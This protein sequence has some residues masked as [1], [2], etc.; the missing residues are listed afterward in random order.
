MLVF[1]FPFF[2]SGWPSPRGRGASPGRPLF[3][4]EA[5]LIGA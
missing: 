3:E 4:S 2:A 1:V 5:P